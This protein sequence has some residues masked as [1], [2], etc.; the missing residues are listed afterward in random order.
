MEEDLCISGLGTAARK[1]L[2]GT[3]VI[4]SLLLGLLALLQSPGP[5]PG[6]FIKRRN[7][8]PLGQAPLQPLLWVDLQV[9][10]PLYALSGV[11]KSRGHQAA[12][13]G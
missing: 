3:V 9:Q 10:V 12:E 5:S 8:A 11:S 13:A 1:G 2:T 7:L 4:L 6:P